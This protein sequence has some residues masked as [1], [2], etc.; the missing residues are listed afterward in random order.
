MVAPEELKGNMLV[1]SHLVNGVAMAL[2]RFKRWKE[3]TRSERW[4]E[5]E[6]MEGSKKIELHGP[7][8]GDEEKKR[9]DDPPRGQCHRLTAD[10]EY[11]GLGESSGGPPTATGLMQPDRRYRVETCPLQQ[12]EGRRRNHCMRGVHGELHRRE[13]AGRMKRWRKRSEVQR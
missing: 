6:R 9:G 1:I 12:A 10:V 7:R 11:R 5:A 2:N 8:Q 13:G 3:K 4:G